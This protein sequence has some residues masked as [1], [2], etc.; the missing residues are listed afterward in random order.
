MREI[1][2]NRNV[3]A[4]SIAL[5]GLIA[6]SITALW[7]MLTSSVRLSSF[8]W[9][10]FLG[11]ITGIEPNSYSLALGAIFHLFFSV[12]IA[13]VYARIFKMYNRS[14]FLNGVMVG[15]AQ[16]LIVGVLVGAFQSLHPFVPERSPG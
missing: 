11:S 14:G 4:T 8:N 16:W 5:V 3:S 6:G 9:I 7:I 1:G 12:I 13:F 10:I 2:D 15:M